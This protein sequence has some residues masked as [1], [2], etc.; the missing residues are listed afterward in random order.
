M[1]AIVNGKLVFPDRIIDGNILIENGIIIASGMI[2]VPLE[3]EVIDAEGLYV[4]PGFIDQ[5]SHGYQ[6]C[7]KGISVNDDPGAAAMEHL[8]HGTTS[9][10]PSSDYGDSEEVH[11]QMIRHCI[12]E[13]EHN[14]YTSIVG[15]HLE[16]PYINKNYGS[17]TDHAMEYSD[18]GCER[19]FSLASPYVLQCTYAPELET[20]PRLEEKMRKYHIHPAVGHSEAG[21]ADIE[22]AIANGANIFNHL[23]DA[24][25]NYQG[26]SEA[27]KN[28]QHP[29]E[30]TSDIALSIPGMYYELICD[31]NGLHV[32]KTNA[33][34]AYRAAGEDHIILISDAFPEPSDGMGKNLN[35]YSDVNYDFR[36]ILSGSRLTLSKATRNFME[37]TGV[38][39][40]VA[41]KCAATNAAKALGIY[42]I[43][44]SI[45]PGRIANIV[46]VN[47]EFH[48]RKIIFRGN[49]ITEIRD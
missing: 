36:G 6:D 20:A 49:E 31:M 5:H 44:G 13:I 9:Y 29:Q 38:D 21:P 34:L 22:R 47:K 39:I 46:F 48:V 15:I 18:E 3:A 40:R 10:V 11:I 17:F 35:P 42:N 8:K 28:T 19:L 43:V 14:P 25:G 2:D 37:F 32:T 16:G 4:G 26:I 45:E 1:K 12:D 41:F 23:F 27:A 24:T 7:S 30:C 33:N